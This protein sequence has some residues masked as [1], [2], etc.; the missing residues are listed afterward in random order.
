M[1]YPKIY[2][3]ENRAVL[4]CRLSFELSCVDKI[5][6]FLK[7]ILNSAFSFLENT[8]YPEICEEYKK[9]EKENKKDSFCYFYS[10][11]ITPVF[12]DDEYLSLRI[13]ATLKRK[14]R[15]CVKAYDRYFVFK[16]SDGSILPYEHFVSKSFRKKYRKEG[17]ENYY[18]KD[19]ELVFFARN[20]DEYRFSL[21]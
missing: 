1:T 18:L 8:L 4:K 7:S 6:D 21:I 19:K 9:G 5:D 17:Y 11:E 14:N 13:K 10:L 3:C 20:G 2:Y 12:C 16:K 15:A